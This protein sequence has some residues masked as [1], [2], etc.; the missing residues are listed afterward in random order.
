MVLS[1]FHSK[2]TFPTNKETEMFT[3]NGINNGLSDL[4]FNH[5]KDDAKMY[6]NS[7]TGVVFAGYDETLLQQNA[8][9]F[10]AMLA[11]AGLS[12]ASIPTSDQLIEDFNSRF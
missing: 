7:K 5:D 12:T 3:R 11:T 1:G 9:N 4:F 6:E 10:I 2:G 8:D